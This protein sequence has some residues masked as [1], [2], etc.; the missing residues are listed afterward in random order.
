MSAIYPKYKSALNRGLVGDIL[1]ANIKA[2]IIDTGVYTYASTHEFLSDL[3]G[4]V[5]TSPNLTGL[6]ESNG[7]V[8]AGNT[9]FTGV[10]GAS[11]EAVAYYIDTGT[12]ATSRL[13]S[14]IDGLSLTPDGGNI[15]LT[16]NNLYNL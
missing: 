7:V 13:I 8:D 3:T 12:P 15:D 2:V 4:V 1:S 10:T 6:T 5:A 14:Y 9:T 11:V 16:V